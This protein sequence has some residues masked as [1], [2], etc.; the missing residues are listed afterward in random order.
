MSTGWPRRSTGST[1]STRIAAAG[2]WSASTSPP[3][4]PPMRTSMPTPS[5]EAARV[6]TSPLAE[7]QR[8]LLRPLHH[9]RRRLTSVTG[10]AFVEQLLAALVQL[11]VTLVFGADQVV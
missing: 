2:R 9:H 5:R 6:P 1:R 10:R 11:G 3:S 4:A 8:R 7:R